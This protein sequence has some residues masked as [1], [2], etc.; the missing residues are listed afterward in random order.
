MAVKT[1]TTAAFYQELMLRISSDDERLVQDD[2]I[3]WYQRKSLLKNKH[4]FNF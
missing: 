4:N 3:R 1:G 2:E